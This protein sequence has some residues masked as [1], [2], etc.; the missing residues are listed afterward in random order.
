MEQQIETPSLH[1]TMA[2]LAERAVQ[3]LTAEG[4]QPGSKVWD[5]VSTIGS[6]ALTPGHVPSLDS[7]YEFV[8]MAHGL[9]AASAAVRRDKRRIKTPFGKT[10]KQWADELHGLGQLFLTYAVGDIERL[11]HLAE[12]CLTPEEAERIRKLAEYHCRPETGEISESVH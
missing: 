4:V 3:E 9:H 12:L 5:A 1:D 2:A 7:L 6:R 10:P 11:A 8:V